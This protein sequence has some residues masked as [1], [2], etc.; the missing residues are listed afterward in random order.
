MKK[1]KAESKGSEK[2]ISKPV[3]LSRRF[4]IINKP[5]IYIITAR[6]NIP[7]NNFI[8]YSPTLTL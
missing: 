6:D 3:D 2:N 1:K 4:Q 5:E 7:I 8:L